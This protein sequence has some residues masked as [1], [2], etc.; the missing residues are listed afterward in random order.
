LHTVDERIKMTGHIEMVKFYYNLIRNFQAPI[1]G[2]RTFSP[3][4]L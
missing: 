3:S 4:E 1:D 2:E